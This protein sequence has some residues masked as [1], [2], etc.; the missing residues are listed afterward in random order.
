[1]D[2]RRRLEW[3]QKN[4]VSRQRLRKVGT[5]IGEMAARIAS[6]VD[7]TARSFAGALEGKVDETFRRHCRVAGIQGGVLV[8]KVDQPGLLYVMRQ[9]WSAPLSRLC[10]ASRGTGAR[11]SVRFELG[12]SGVRV[13]G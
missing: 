11:P 10:A 8:I 6:Q 2:G 4:R 1:M 3:V 7:G 5:L 9:Q 13:G 12:D